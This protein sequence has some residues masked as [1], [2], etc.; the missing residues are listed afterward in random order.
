MMLALFASLTF[1]Q[2]VAAQANPLPAA[3]TSEAHA[4]FD[5]WIGEW[6]VYP[7]GS[8]NQVATSRVERLHAGCALREQWMPVQGEGGSSL[9][10]LDRSTGRWH[11]LWIGSAGETVRFEGGPVDGRMVLT[12]YWADYDGP[13]RDAL[14]RM[15]FTPNADG[16]VRQYG[17]VSHDHG[18][19]WR[20]GFDFIYRKR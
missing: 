13:G 16:S 5:F 4:A 7:V 11:Q 18:L 14:V 8:V 12:G 17:E 3:C 20:P 15:I 6:N 19:S 9:N 2:I 1:A 10:S